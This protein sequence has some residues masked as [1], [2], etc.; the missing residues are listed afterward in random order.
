[1]NKIVSLSHILIAK[2]H[3]FGDYSSLVLGTV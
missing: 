1:M 3:F 2:H